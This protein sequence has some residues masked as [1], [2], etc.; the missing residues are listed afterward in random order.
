[1]T[2]SVD[3]EWTF[4]QKTKHPE[5]TCSVYISNKFY[6]TYDIQYQVR[7]TIWKKDDTKQIFMILT[8][9]AEE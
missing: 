9:K 3:P 7:R 4:A 5:F 8:Y 6:A 1:M 2:Q